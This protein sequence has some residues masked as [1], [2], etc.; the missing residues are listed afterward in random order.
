MKC[1]LVMFVL[2]VFSAACGSVPP[3]GTSTNPTS[4]ANQTGMMVSLGAMEW[5]VRLYENG[6]ASVE[7]GSYPFYFEP[8]TFD[9]QAIVHKLKSQLSPERSNAVPGA[10]G[11]TFFGKTRAEDMVLWA[12]D[13][14]PAM[15]VFELVRRAG[16]KAAAGGHGTLEKLWREDPPTPI[17]LSWDAREDTGA[18]PTSGPSP[19]TQP[20]KPS[21]AEPK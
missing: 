9:A 5:N 3:A 15:E 12:K 18:T 17:S 6:S 21:K 8:G 2:T 7:H 10:Y 4:N 13:P 14:R 11:A 20:A 16:R 19:S 1:S